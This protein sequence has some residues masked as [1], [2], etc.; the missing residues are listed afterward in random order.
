MVPLIVAVA[1]AAGVTLVGVSVQVE[2]G[3]APVQVASTAALKPFTEVTVTVKLA[4]APAVTVEEAGATET[5][6]SGP[7][8]VPENLVTKASDDPLRVF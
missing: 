5:A 1:L 6:K 8:A 2:P 7:E 3:G 4:L